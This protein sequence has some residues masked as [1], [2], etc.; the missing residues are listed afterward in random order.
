M[1]TL[2]EKIQ[3]VKGNL[4]FYQEILEFHGKVREEQERIKDSLR[5]EPLLVSKEWKNLF[6]KEGVPLLRKEDFPVD[7]EIGAQ[8]FKFL[9]S[10]AIDANPFLFEQVKRVEEAIKGKRLQVKEIL[11]Q[12]PKDDETERVAEE[13]GFDKKVF[14]F[15][16]QNSVKPFIEAGMEQ[17]SKEI[18]SEIWVKGICPICGSLPFLSLLRG[19][20]GKRSLLCS[21]CGY[22]W[23]TERRLCPFCN[24]KGQASLQYFYDEEG[25]AC[26]I[27]LCEECH[28]YI[29]TIDLRKKDVP[30]PSLEDLATLHLD[31]VARERGYQRPVPTLFFF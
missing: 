10:V 31:M 16:I 7:V 15:L 21:F 6:A 14:L 3:Q 5:I 23:G 9:C 25:G 18:E 20:A 22:E 2:R 30:D 24:N 4:P 27:D 12:K 8:L 29:K 17:I 13:S 19:E 11:R 1:E 26:R 28:Q